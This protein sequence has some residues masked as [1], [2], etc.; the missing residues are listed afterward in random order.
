ME[1]TFFETPSAFR[2]W[3]EQHHDQADELWVGY[4]KKGSGN[5]SI[6]WP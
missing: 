4:Y 2:A 5:P 1:P 3:L 6:P